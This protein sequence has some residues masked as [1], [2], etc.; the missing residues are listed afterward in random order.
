VKT[1]NANDSLMVQ[2]QQCNSDQLVVKMGE[3]TTKSMPYPTQIQ[4]LPTVSNDGHNVDAN[5]KPMV[6]PSPY[7]VRNRESANS[8]VAIN[9]LGHKKKRSAMYVTNDS[10]GSRRKIGGNIKSNSRPKDADSVK[11]T[12]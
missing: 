8:V 6:M 5:N 9:K 1:E 7:D 10:E 11:N 3:Q 12:L 4:S 2:E